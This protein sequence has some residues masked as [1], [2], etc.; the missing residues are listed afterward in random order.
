M[1]KR[2]QRG[3][4]LSLCF[5][6]IAAAFQA[7]PPSSGLVLWWTLDD[8]VTTD[9]SGTGNNGTVAG[10]PTPQPADKPA[11][12]FNNVQSMS[13]DGTDDQVTRAAV[14]GL[15]IGNTPHTMAMW[16]KI[17]AFPSARAWI[18]LLGTPEA[19]AHHWLINQTGT[20]QFGVWGG[21]QKAPILAADGQW[22][23][24]A[25]V[26]DGTTLEVY[27]NGTAMGGG[28]IAATFGLKGVP[29]TIAQKQIAESNFPGLLDDVRVYDRA[30][31]AAEVQYLA[32]GNGPPAAPG[33]FQAQGVLGSVNLSWNAVAGATGY[34]VRRGAV[35]GGPYS[36]VVFSGA[37]TSFTDSTGLTAGST[38]Y[39]VVTAFHSAGGES[40]NSLQAQATPLAPPPRT[41]PVGNEND[42]CGCGTAGPAS[43][44]WLLALLPALALVALRLRR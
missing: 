43:P 3:V 37:G 9:A 35:S 40:A 44:L 8:A 23:H 16:V 5:G 14:T 32:A 15:A 10:G 19:G 11:L 36:T 4:F 34:V 31:T 2:I 42:P 27:I 41:A 24:V 1:G 21:A 39:Y 33:N 26:F 7:T 22:R 28:A 6:L 30:L 38:Y 29:F 12:N 17:N 18:A 20:T 25:S 13:F